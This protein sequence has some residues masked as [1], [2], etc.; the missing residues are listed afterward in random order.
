MAVEEVQLPDE[1]LERFGQ[2]IGAEKAD[3]MRRLTAH[4]RT[5]LKDHTVWNV[6]STAAGGGVAEMLQVLVAYVRGAGVDGRWLVAGGNRDFFWIT[7]RMHNWLHDDPGDGG[8]LGPAERE[9]YDAVTAANAEQLRQ[10]IRPGDVVICH[11]PQTAGLV[12]ALD[13]DVTTIWRCHVGSES[14]GER[15]Q[16]AQDFLRPYLEGADACV[17]SRKAHIHSWMPTE[18]VWVIPPSIDPFSPKNQDLDPTAVR[19]IVAQLGLLPSN[20]QEPVYR[21]RD[22]SPAHVTRTA[23]V[24]RGGPTPDPDVPLVLQ[25]SRWDRLKDMRGV[26]EGFAAGVDGDAHLVLAGP[27]VTGVADDPESSQVL[28]DCARVWDGLPAAAQRRIHLLCLPMEDVG[29][30]AA[31]VNALQR[32]ATVVTQK[33]LQEGF[34]LTVAEAMWKTRPVVA[35]AVGGIQDQIVDDEHGVLLSDPTDLTHFGR[36]VGELLGDPE[37]AGRL[38]RSARTRV[39]ERF[40]GTRHLADY[41]RLLDELGVGS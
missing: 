4:T 40:L 11:D 19:A 30:N 8:S 26:M 2:L 27:S 6:N 33:S 21:R 22:G 35:S 25:V 10:V 38:G 3:R 17:F 1:P 7:K 28:A 15:S 32:H 20:E 18:R 39:V 29:E 31:M 41:A 12:G 36:M 16:Q 5:R 23:E 34:G 9:H 24:I 14:G 37:R 13:S